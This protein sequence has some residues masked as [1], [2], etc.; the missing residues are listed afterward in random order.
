VPFFEVAW[1]FFGAVKH[2][3]ESQPESGT[4]F[5]VDGYGLTSQEAHATVQ[6]INEAFS[7]FDSLLASHSQAQCDDYRSGRMTNESYISLTDRHSSEGDDFRKAQ[8]ES[9]LDTL[10]DESRSRLIP[11][12]EEL[13]SSASILSVDKSERVA[14][15]FDYR[16]AI[17][18]R[19]SRLP[20]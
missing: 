19:C 18:R 3:E 5:L 4:I 1:S 7:E 14:M 20:L 15:G 16:A 13:R 12:M 10:K 6:M 9:V 17:A 11:K 8:V 2:F